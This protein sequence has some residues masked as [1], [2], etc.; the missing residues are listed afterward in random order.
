[1]AVTDPTK[2][3]GGQ[4]EYFVGTKEEMADLA[5]QGKTPPRERVMAPAF[6]GPGYAIALHGNMVVHRGAALNKPAERITMVNG[7]VAMDTRCE[8]QHR[9]RDLTVVDD[10]NVLYAEWARH[11]A[12]RARSRLDTL[13]EEIEFTSDRMHVAQQLDDAIAD[14]Q[15]AVQELRDQSEHQIHH[16]E[17]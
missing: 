9:H 1:M 11:A 4:F 10:P 17:K 2:L 14:A 6:R 3:D 8:D 13:L 12:W 15:K 7:Y 5:A 16:Y